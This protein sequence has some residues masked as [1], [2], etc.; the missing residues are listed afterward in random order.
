MKQMTEFYPADAAER[1]QRSN[2]IWK[3]LTAGI[4]VS[5][6]AVCIVLVSGVT[7]ANAAGRELLVCVIS[8]IAG[9]VVIFLCKHFVFGLQRELIHLHTLHD[10]PREAVTGEVLT[11]GRRFRIP[12]SITVQT[13]HVQT[14]TET[15]RVSINT[16]FLRRLPKLPARLT[17]YTVHGYVVAYEE[18]HA[19]D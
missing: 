2:K 15:R 12:S 1:L 13:L 4:A 8:A 18:H 9:W 10:E 3:I 7:T 6:L 14:G 11:D 5:A 16:R 17:L 19:A